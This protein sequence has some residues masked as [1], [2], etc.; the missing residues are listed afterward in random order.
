MTT[1]ANA[2]QRRTLTPTRLGTL[3]TNHAAA[4][5]PTTAAE[6]HAWLDT[7]APRFVDA[8]AWSAVKG[9]VIDCARE[10]VDD[11]GVTREALPRYTL[12]LVKLAQYCRRTHQPLNRA[13]ILDPYTVNQF[14][15]AIATLD[16]GSA[17]TYQANL[18]FIGQR[19]S[20]GPMW[21]RPTPVNRRA[22]PVPY[23]PA[24]LAELRAQVAK[25]TPDRRRG[26]EALMTLGLGA[27]LDGRWA[28]KV[29]REDIVDAGDGPAV[30]V[31]GRLVPVL[32]THEDDLE[33]L[34]A[35]TPPGDLLVGGSAKH[36][37]AANEIAAR[38][39]LDPSCP[40]LSS[41][42]LR[43]TWIVTHLTL[44]TRLPEL[45]ELAEAAGTVGITTF[46]DLLEFVPL[47]PGTA[48]QSQW[49]A[50]TM[51]RGSK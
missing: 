14:A 41:G 47:L 30:A 3:A 35:D 50:R 18:R 49:S 16:T 43:S 12:A 29:A 27:G 33:Q 37:N 40:R 24:E 15:A 8:K 44:G 22:V 51:L 20:P 38:V 45:A 46:S 1:G 28:A 9:F 2:A 34:L 5:E 21:E 11:H 26:G 48:D 6:A 7:Y 32:R 36:K 31:D 17:G 23:S 42:R 39:R 13:T 4:K 19:L 10:L 25:N